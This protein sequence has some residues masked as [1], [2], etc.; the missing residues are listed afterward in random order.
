V[1]DVAVVPKETRVVFKRIAN[2]LDDARAKQELVPSQVNPSLFMSSDGVE[3]RL[4]NAFVERK[5]R[6]DDS[7][8][9]SRYRD[10]F[11]V[12]A[13]LGPDVDAFFD[14]KGGV[15]VMDPD[16]ALRG[17][18]LALL[19]QIRA[20]FALIADFSPARRCLVKFVKQ[21]GG[22]SAEGRATDKA[23]L[24][25]KGANLAE[26]AS[27]GC[28]LPPGFTITTEVCR[29]VMEHGVD[30]YPEGLGRRGP[31]GAREGRTADP[32]GRSATRSSRCW[33]ACDRA[34][35]RR[36]PA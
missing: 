12:L 27:L 28:R 7:L 34:R 32:G 1:R 2:I 26:M 35:R 30:H 10:C 20:P 21:F 36:C 23:L 6:L 19:E 11:T 31:R 8:T 15:M 33:S 18:R 29:H 22:G 9:R 16:L 25:G 24:G 14:K 13:E 4:W 17:N 5:A 3:A